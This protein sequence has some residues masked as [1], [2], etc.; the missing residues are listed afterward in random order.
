MFPFGSVIFA[1]K[2]VA[3]F[4][5]TVIS[6]RAE[7]AF[8]IDEVI[9]IRRFALGKFVSEQASTKK[10]V[11]SSINSEYGK[12]LV[13]DAELLASAITQRQI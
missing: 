1:V 10:F 2:P 11:D 12:V 5:V 13:V 3:S 6:N 9:G 8:V 4:A 7:F